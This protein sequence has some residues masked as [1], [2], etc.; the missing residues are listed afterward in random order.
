LSEDD[1]ICDLAE[2]YQIYDYKQLP[3][4]QVAIFVC[5]LRE[6]SRIMIRNS[7]QKISLDKFMKASMV[8]SLNFLAW[9]KTKDAQKG[10]NQ[11]K[12]FVDVLLG[13]NENNEIKKFQSGEEFL[14]A[15][16]S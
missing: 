11:P 16:N 5:G 14:T 10:H 8:D 13:K 4:F 2:T 7:G 15:W 1:I 12:K 3:L 6:D 9:S